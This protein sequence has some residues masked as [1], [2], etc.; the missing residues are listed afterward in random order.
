MCSCFCE[1]CKSDECFI[2]FANYA[3]VASQTIGKWWD[4]QEWYTG[5]YLW[6]SLKRKWTWCHT[7]RHC[8]IFQNTFFD[9]VLIGCLRKWQKVRHISL[10]ALC[11]EPLGLTSVTAI[12]LARG[13]LTFIKQLLVKARYISK[14]FLLIA[15]LL[16]SVQIPQNHES[17]NLKSLSVTTTRFWIVCLLLMLW[18]K[19]DV[20]PLRYL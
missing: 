6:L 4:D 3:E 20:S 12:D 13:L 17:L 14:L 18:Q 8:H 16:I 10:V 9:L 11:I 2:S 7:V 15:S 1:I 5:H 19:T